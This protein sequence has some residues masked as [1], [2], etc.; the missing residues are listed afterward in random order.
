MKHIS[1]SAQEIQ[2][3]DE[4]AIHEIGI[5]SVALMENA[6]KSLA[7]EVHRELK[8]KKRVGIVCGLGN[9]AGDGFVAARHLINQNI[10]LLISICH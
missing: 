9:N 10:L 6:G 1:L 7:D 5:P 3:L 2:E 8:N 4:K